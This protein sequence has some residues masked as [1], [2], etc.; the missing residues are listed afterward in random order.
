MSDIAIAGGFELARM[1]L[2]F[3]LNYMRMNGASEAEIE[4]QYQEEKKLFFSNDP[5]N[6]PDPE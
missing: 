6:L 1:A 5:A 4:A 3:W 2:S